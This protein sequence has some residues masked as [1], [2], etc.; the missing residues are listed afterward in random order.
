MSETSKIF[1]F[2]DEGQELASFALEQKEMAFEY[3]EKLEEMGISVTLKEP[4]LPESLIVSLGA[5]TTDREKLKREIDEEIDAHDSPC[6]GTMSATTPSSD[7][8]ARQE[9]LH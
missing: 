2:D 6:C 5:G 3:A 1:L 4:S 7:T 8:T 9:K